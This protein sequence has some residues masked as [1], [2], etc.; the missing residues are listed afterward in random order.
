M[1]IFYILCVFFIYSCTNIDESFYIEDTVETVEIE[2]DT[3]EFEDETVEIEKDTVEF[4][5]LSN[6]SNVHKDLV[7]NRCNF[8]CKTNEDCAYWNGICAIIYDGY[9]VRSLCTEDCSESKECSESGFFC[10]PLY[11][12]SITR[13]NW[14]CMPVEGPICQ[15]D[16]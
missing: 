7:V 9:K 6:N 15:G 10:I 16:E 13:F 3:V 4:P 1:R 8:F 2:K 12:G 5:D 14:Q 11:K